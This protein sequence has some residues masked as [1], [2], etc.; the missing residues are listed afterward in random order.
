LKLGEGFPGVASPLMLPAGLKRMWV[1]GL[2]PTLGIDGQG[3]QQGQSEKEKAR[4]ND[5]AFNVWCAGRDSNS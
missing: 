5:Q 3:R 1:S 4:S 2:N